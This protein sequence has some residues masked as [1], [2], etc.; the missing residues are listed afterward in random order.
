VEILAKNNWAAATQI[1]SFSCL[2]EWYKFDVFWIQLGNWIVAFIPPC[3]IAKF[4]RIMPRKSWTGPSRSW[5]SEFRPWPRVSG[6]GETYRRRLTPPLP[7]NWIVK[8]IPPCPIA[9]FTRIMPRKSWTGPSRS[10]SPEF[11][12]WPRLS[13][14]EETYRRRQTTPPP[15]TELSNICCAQARPPRPKRIAFSTAPTIPV[16]AAHYNGPCSVSP[17]VLPPQELSHGCVLLC[18]LTP[19]RLI[20]VCLIFD[21]PQRCTLDRP[22]CRSVQQR[23]GRFPGIPRPQG[24][25]QGLLLRHFMQCACCMVRRA[26]GDDADLHR[27]KICAHMTPLTHYNEGPRPPLLQR[28]VRCRQG[29]GGYRSRI[30]SLSMSVSLW[31]A[32]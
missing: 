12:P 5:S 20:V 30:T 3:P 32:W 14:H 22:R 27:N 6:H 26:G 24:R 17:D 7:T 15:P 29:R 28:V 18:W 11:R 19:G 25:R 21:R 13:G 4:T 2:L 8:W 23:R 10:W 1:F 9:N 16:A 31:F